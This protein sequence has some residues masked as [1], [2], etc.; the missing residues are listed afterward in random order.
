MDLWY[1]LTN[2]IH[3]AFVGGQ[4]SGYVATVVLFSMFVPLDMFNLFIRTGYSLEDIPARSHLLNMLFEIPMLFFNVYVL[5]TCA[6]PAAVWR[7][8][9]DA[10]VHLLCAWCMRS[11]CSSCRL[12]RVRS[13][14]RG[15]DALLQCVR[16]CAPRALAICGQGPSSSASARASRHRSSETCWPQA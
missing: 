12:M 1:D 15:A 14:H 3:L 6:P 8:C 11:V 7:V 16:S 13:C 2:F 4:N 5:L 9:P 10:L